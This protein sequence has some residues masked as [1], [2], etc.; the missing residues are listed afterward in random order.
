MKNAKNPELPAFPIEA[1]DKTIYCG[2]SKREYLAGMLLQGILSRGWGVTREEL[3]V[4]EA[5]KFADAIL[6]E[7]EE[8][9]RASKA[10]LWKK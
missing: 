3:M 5:V 7:L 6:M 4:E 10:N 2:L 8:N 1:H 9:G